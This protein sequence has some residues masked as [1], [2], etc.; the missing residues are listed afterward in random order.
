MEMA[1]MFSGCSADPDPAELFEDLLKL[2]L[3]CH[4]ND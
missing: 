1:W 3:S 2:K 4:C